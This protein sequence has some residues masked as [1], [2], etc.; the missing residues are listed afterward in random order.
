MVESVLVLDPQERI[1]FMNPAASRLLKLES[2]G[3]I[4]KKLWQVIRHRR[5]S[6]AFE[7]V[8][9]SSEPYHAD[10]ELELPESRFLKIQGSQLR[11]AASRG[12]LLVLHDVTELRRL[13]RVRQD[14]F[15]NVSHEIKTRF[16]RPW[17]HS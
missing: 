5:I 6:E 3:V 4:G 17:K 8:M 12:A 14:F 2:E 11:G 9:Q 1:V 13:E 7:A 15:T 16:K 10:L